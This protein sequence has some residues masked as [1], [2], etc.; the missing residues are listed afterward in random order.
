MLLRNSLLLIAAIAMVLFPMTVAL[1]ASGSIRLGSIPLRCPL[2]FIGVCCR[3]FSFPP[4][5]FIYQILANECV[6]NSARGILAPMVE[7]KPKNS[8]LCTKQISPVCCFRSG[9]YI[10]ETNSCLCKCYSGVVVPPR[11]SCG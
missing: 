11:V 1:P 3:S 8:C 5:G 9:I 6:C 7:C 4:P 2:I 10:T